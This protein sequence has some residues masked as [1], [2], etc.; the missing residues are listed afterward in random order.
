QEGPPGWGPQPP[1]ASRGSQVPSRRRVCHIDH[2]AAPKRTDPPPRR[3]AIA[4]PPG[5]S[6]RLRRQKFRADAVPPSTG[7]RTNAR[8]SSV[9][10]SSIEDGCRLSR[11]PAAEDG[12]ADDAGTAVPDGP[13]G[14]G[15]AGGEI[16]RVERGP[17]R[18]PG[19]VV[20]GRVAGDVEAAQG[21]EVDAQGTDG[22]ELAV[23]RRV[24][25]G[26]G[27]EGGGGCA[28]GSIPGDGGGV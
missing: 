19:V 4:R 28:E 7:K 17:R 9:L 11:R 21:P 26:G 20:P 8:A 12:E 14:P 23:V 1:A 24:P 27:G 6:D 22:G 16:D 10:R 5:K 25:E 2:R 18:R 3:S 15:G 13:G